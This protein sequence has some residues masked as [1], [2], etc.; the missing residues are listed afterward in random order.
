MVEG[1][2]EAVGMGGSGLEEENSQEE[3]ADF[4]I[5]GEDK[6]KTGCVSL[7]DFSL[8]LQAAPAFNQ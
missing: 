2:F 6:C 8:A 5:H 1:V 3:K 7:G 4:A